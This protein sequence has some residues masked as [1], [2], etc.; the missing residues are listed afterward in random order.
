MPESHVW[1]LLEAP[2]ETLSQKRLLVITRPQCL[3]KYR[4]GADGISSDT[5]FEISVNKIN[6]DK[7]GETTLAFG[8]SVSMLQFSVVSAQYPN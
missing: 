7:W 8:Y 5:I 4:A 6:Q 3:V 2:L 1:C